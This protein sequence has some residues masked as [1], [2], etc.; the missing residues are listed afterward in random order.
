[1]KALKSLVS[2]QPPFLAV[3][4]LMRASFRSFGLTKAFIFALVGV[5]IFSIDAGAQYDRR[6][7]T[8]NMASYL[9]L[10]GTE[11]D[12]SPAVVRALQDC[13]RLG[14]RR[15]VFPKGEWRFRPDSLTR[16]MT[17]ISNNGSYMRCFAFD[18][19]GQRRLEIDGG[20]SLFLF[21]GYVCPFYVNRAQGITLR[22]FTVD[23]VRT[24]H[25]EGHIEA[26]TDS[27]MDVRFS[28]QYPYTID[29][30]GHLHFVDDE[31][32]EY[33]WYYLLEYDP[34]RMETAYMVRDQWTGA[35]IA[36]EDLGQGRVRLHRQGLKGTVGNVM[37]FGIAY[38]TVPAITLSDSRDVSI[39]NVTLHHAGGMGVVAQRTRNIM[40]DSLLVMP[41]P[42]K[43][44]VNSVAADATHFVNCSGYLKIYHSVM[45]NQTDDASNIHGVYY[46]IVDALSDRR[47][48][49]EIANDAQ[50]GFDIFSPGVK[51]EFASPKSLVTYAHATVKSA[52]RI[53]DHKF[54]VT[55]AGD[56]PSG[57]KAGD[58]IAA[59][60]D[61]P[62]VHI[63]DCY[64]GG[65][66]ARGL[67]LGSRARMLIEHNVFRTPGTALLLEGDGRYW[68]EQAGVRDVVIRDNTFDN[69][70]FGVWNR[71]AIGCGSGIER[72]YYDRSF[73]NR[74][75]LIENNKFLIHRAPVLYLY[76][77]D[78]ITFRGNTIV[79]DGSKYPCSVKPGDTD[80]LFQLVDCRN[81]TH[82]E[83]KIE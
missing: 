8:L 68:F 61:Y 65:N 7:R 37:S 45:V 82:D 64:F 77:V 1:M 63:K 71:G 3:A 36:T 35:D 30:R 49:V 2:S 66:R 73:Y 60:G 59:E 20:G 18:L 31:G 81:F 72:E 4:E 34:K 10:Y 24:F 47:L 80:A 28:Q 69:C 48:C 46:R 25:S 58:I 39:R 29:D 13:K 23:Y 52:Y 79:A 43:D 21:K 11:A 74:N 76:S 22:N 32:T 19:T 44:R 54:M 12:R 16:M 50:H 33:P 83:V 75:L 56:I 53:N 9:S 6:T 70:N 26:V 67:L 78:G 17:H 55:L 42:G 41:A 62:E 40:I 15:M 5:V 51:L 27:A 38:R 57:V 14:A